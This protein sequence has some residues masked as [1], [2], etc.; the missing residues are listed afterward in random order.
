[1]RNEPVGKWGTIGLGCG[2][3]LIGGK[4]PPGGAGGVVRFSESLMYPPYWRNR[5][6]AISF[7][8]SL[9][10]GPYEIRGIN[11]Q[12]SFWREESTRY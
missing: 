11:I 9:V 1:M 8:R 6:L 7:N 12:G 4:N 3:N 10:L 2:A 5:L